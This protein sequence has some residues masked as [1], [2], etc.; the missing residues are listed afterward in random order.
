MTTY[1]TYQ[2]VLTVGYTHDISNGQSPVSCGGVH[3]IEI[4]KTASGW[5]KR[6]RQ[7][8]G[9]GRE[10]V[11]PGSDITEAVAQRLISVGKSAR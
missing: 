9:R 3:H 2:T 6:I 10:F 4:R 1:R 7:S 5:R 8:T 11:G